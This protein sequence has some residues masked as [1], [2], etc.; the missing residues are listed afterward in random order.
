MFFLPNKGLNIR[1]QSVYSREVPLCAHA[2]AQKHQGHQI[3]F[4][5]L[6]LFLFY[7][8]KDQNMCVLLPASVVV[9]E[10][11]TE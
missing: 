4:F 3:L 2:E 7:N 9:I 10:Y 8:A 5:K 11:T 6:F 1:A